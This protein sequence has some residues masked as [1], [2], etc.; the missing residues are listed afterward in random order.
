MFNEFWDKVAL[1]VL[2]VI[3]PPI[4]T[5]LL[6]WLPG[7]FDKLR[8]SRLTQRITLTS[9]AVSLF[10]C[11][12]FITAYDLYSRRRPD[13]GPFPAA[14]VTEIRREMH[15]FS[16]PLHNIT[17]GSLLVTVSAY[18][19][20]GANSMC[21]SVADDVSKLTIA[22]V[23]N[24]GDKS[25]VAVSSFAAG[26][27]QTPMVFVVPKGF[28]YNVTNDAPPDKVITIAFWTEYTL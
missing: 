1:I 7:A 13:P 19:T 9:S 12:F 2:G 14:K 5:W 11:L 20:S 27:H 15:K 17:N 21:A 18:N 4:V 26:G 10:L 24:C 28:W 6:Q 8:P 22:K 3:I 16:E 25:T 23:T